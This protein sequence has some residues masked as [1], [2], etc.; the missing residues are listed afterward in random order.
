MLK[1]FKAVLYSLN[2]VMFLNDL[3]GFEIWVIFLQFFLM[4]Y[5]VVIYLFWKLFIFICGI[6]G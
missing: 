3:S 4:R 6:F 1:F 2:F 5:F